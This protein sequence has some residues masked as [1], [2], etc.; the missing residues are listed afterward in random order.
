[1]SELLFTFFKD[2][3]IE[4]ILLGE[5]DPWFL[6]LTKNEDVTLSGGENVSIGILKMD[7]I[8]S[9]DMFF[10]IGDNTN[11]SDVVTGNDISNITHF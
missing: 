8:E 1:M 4:T 5:W 9:T 6:S 10:D 11:T 7:D 3:Q 2:W